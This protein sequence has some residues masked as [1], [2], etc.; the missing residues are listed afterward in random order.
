MDYNISVFWQNINLYFKIVM[1]IW[2]LENPN[3]L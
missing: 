3:P 2:M 1:D